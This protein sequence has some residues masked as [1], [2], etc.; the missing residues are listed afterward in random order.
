MEKK[1]MAQIAMGMK[2]INFD[3]QKNCHS[4]A[5][6]NWDN[7]KKIKANETMME[8]TPSKLNDLPKL[9]TTP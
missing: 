5:K 1:P 3:W 2:R 6:K 7:A 4:G 9:E 8:S